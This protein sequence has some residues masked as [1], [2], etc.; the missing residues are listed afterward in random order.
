MLVVPESRR[1][2][3]PSSAIDRIL[4]RAGKAT[5]HYR[6][7]PWR[8]AINKHIGFPA[9]LLAAAHDPHLHQLMLVD[10]AG[11][12]G[13]ETLLAETK[14]TNGQRELHVYQPSRMAEVL[15]KAQLNPNAH[16][17]QALTWL[18]SGA[19]FLMGLDQWGKP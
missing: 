18:K 3:F 2:T 19:S 12:A 4:A 5:E 7:L 8:V 17:P 16:S 13:Q 9:S 11:A 15:E 6:T 1:S 14:E 10:N